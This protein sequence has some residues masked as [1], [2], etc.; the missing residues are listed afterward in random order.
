MLRAMAK[1][2]WPLAF[3]QQYWLTGKALLSA[4]AA[5]FEFLHY[6]GVLVGIPQKFPLVGEVQEE[7]FPE[8]IFPVA[9]SWMSC[10]AF[11]RSC[12]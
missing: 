1:S 2:V 6:F 7:G 10:V 4:S 11:G 5:T 9:G 12:W 3:C 8:E